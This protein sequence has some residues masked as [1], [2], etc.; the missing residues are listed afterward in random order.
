M[1]AALAA[2]Y[3]IWGSTYLSIKIAIET[4][5]P[6]L[7]A[8]IR[9]LTA[10]AILF[11]WARLSG[12]YEKPKAAHWQTSSVVGALLLLGGNGAVVFAE[13]YIS[14]SLAAL[15][16]ATEP[17]WVVLLVWLWMKGPRPSLK[18]VLGLAI[19]FVGVWLLISGRAVSASVAGAGGNEWFGILAMLIG[20]ISWA[21]GS[22]GR[23]ADAGGRRDAPRSKSCSGRMA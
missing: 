16:I 4:M 15:L 2:V 5:P 17:F 11:A 21:A 22:V 9:F 6:F 3:L 12:D 7:M 18:V 14:S 19:G 10:G 13:N 20:G 8:G 23:H 1:I